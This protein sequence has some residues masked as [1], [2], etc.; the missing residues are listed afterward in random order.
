MKNEELLVVI[1]PN[2]EYMINNFY[3]IETTSGNT[4]IVETH[5]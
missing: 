4:Q 3:S 5:T 2:I 1:I